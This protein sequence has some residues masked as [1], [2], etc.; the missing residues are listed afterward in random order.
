VTGARPT[1]SQALDAALDAATGKGE[2]APGTIEATAGGATVVAE[3]IDVDR[4]G[5]VVERLRVTTGPGDLKLR[6]VRAAERVRP[7]GAALHAIELDTRLGG[8]VLR[9]ETQRDNRFYELGL[10]ETGGVLTRHHK[11][12]NGRRSRE[13]FTVTRAD[14]EQLLDELSESLDS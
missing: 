3:I 11:E 7:G 12:S 8:G 2:N 6:A 13:P 4:L 5:V 10:D 9:T 14:L 1:L